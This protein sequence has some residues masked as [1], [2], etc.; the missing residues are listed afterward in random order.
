MHLDDHLDDGLAC[1]KCQNSELEKEGKKLYCPICGA[2]QPSV[3]GYISICRLI[4]LLTAASFVIWAII[5]FTSGAYWYRNLSLVTCAMG[6]SAVITGFVPRL[7]AQACI[8][9]GGRKL[10]YS[11]VLAIVL[12]VCCLVFFL[13]VL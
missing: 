13:L 11:G 10:L 5:W 4:V 6:L 8:S 7:L 3:Q 2:A 1:H 9:K 12:E